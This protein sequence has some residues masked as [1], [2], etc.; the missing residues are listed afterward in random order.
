MR[1]ALLS[2]LVPLYNEE[3]FVAP[4]LGRVLAA[5]LPEGIQM[6]IVV[7]DDGSSDGSAEVVESIAAQ[8]PRIRLVRHPRNRGKGAAVRTAIEHA[9][10]DISLIQDADL[11]YDPGEYPHLLQPILDDKADVVFG[12]RF[13]VAGGRRVLYYWHSVANH[14]L[15]T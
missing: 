13:M 7:V 9:R 12:S 10:G 11:E 2:V 15:T 3:E 6:E 5:P 8:D 4:L 1:A 14:L